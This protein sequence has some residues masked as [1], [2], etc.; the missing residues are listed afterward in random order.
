MVSRVSNAQHYKS[1]GSR[2][3]SIWNIFS[4]VA[5]GIIFVLCASQKPH[6]NSLAAQ[7]PVFQQDFSGGRVIRTMFWLL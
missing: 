2:V 5:L 7:N 4:G 1:L 3:N 6:A